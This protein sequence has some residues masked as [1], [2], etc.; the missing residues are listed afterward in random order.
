MVESRNSNVTVAV[1]YSEWDRITSKWDTNFLCTS[2]KSVKKM[3]YSELDKLTSK[4]DT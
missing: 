4:W 3:T 2:S 1:T